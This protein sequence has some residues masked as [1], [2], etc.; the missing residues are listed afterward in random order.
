MPMKPRVSH[1]FSK[2]IRG[3]VELYF[4]AN[5]LKKEQEVELIKAA[6]VAILPQSFSI[7]LVPYC[8]LKITALRASADAFG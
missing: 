6:V 1:V 5:T 3:K 7:Y 8:Q 2:S 4:R